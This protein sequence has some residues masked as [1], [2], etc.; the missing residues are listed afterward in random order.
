MI[1]SDEI[2]I[3]LDAL[4][5]AFMPVLEDEGSAA[6]PGK[7]PGDLYRYWE[8]PQGIGLFGL[9]KLYEKTHDDNILD[10][11]VKYY[12]ARLAEG[13]PD[14][15]V[16]TM[17][18]IL[19]LS[20]LAENT[21]RDD[22]MNVCKEWAEWLMNGGL[23]RTP[24]RGFQ[25][26]T[27]NDLNDGELWDDTLMMAVMPLA[28][29]G[30]ILGRRDYQEEALYQIL[31]HIEYLAD[32]VN[33]LWYHGY[34]FNERNHFSGA[35]W[36]RGNSWIT[37]AIPLF[38]EI[39]PMSNANKEYLNTVLERQVKALVPLQDE[40]GLWHTILDDVSSYTESSCTAGFGY[41]I[42]KAIKSGILSSKY[43]ECADKAL[44][45]ILECIDE[46]GILT[47]CSGGTPMGRKSKS[48]YNEIP[49]RPMPYGQAMAMLFLSEYI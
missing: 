41:G 32:P 17:A 21:G 12:D 38:L 34:S 19:A 13:L 1:V 28:V 4:I 31:L 2:H 47:K 22:Y 11:L 43:S 49:I 39:I 18:P 46:N 23:P 25:H 6:C 40:N 10:T 8:W 42:V 15:D 24:E 30:R 33:G 36:G 48:F 27:R 7:A 44:S 26:K 9:W 45:A 20:L 14:K 16:N 29:M 3:K 5:R 37:M 35:F